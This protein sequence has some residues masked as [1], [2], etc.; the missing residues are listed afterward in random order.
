[1]EGLK[2]YHSLGSDEETGERE[3]DDFSKTKNSS[4]F[5]VAQEFAL[6]KE[7]KSDVC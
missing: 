1:M 5:K 6:G 2:L 3:G 4:Y 7:I